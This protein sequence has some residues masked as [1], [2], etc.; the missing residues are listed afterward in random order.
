MDRVLWRAVAGLSEV[1]R[2]L[3]SPLSRGVARSD[4][5][6][7]GG[8]THPEASRIF[9]ISGI[10]LLWP[11]A[12]AIENWRFPVEWPTSVIGTT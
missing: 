11:F 7:N 4:E 9:E 12:V 5:V 10:V 1:L 3:K 2:S 6:C 8:E